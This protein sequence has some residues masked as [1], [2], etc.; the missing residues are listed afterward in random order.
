MKVNTPQTSMTLAT[1][2]MLESPV[3][4]VAVVLLAC[5][6]DLILDVFRQV[7]IVIHKRCGQAG[8]QGTSLI[9]VHWLSHVLERW[10]GLCPAELLKALAGRYQA[11]CPN[12][13]FDQ[14]VSLF[15]SL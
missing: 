11:S 15:N 5:L 10:R 12:E 6:A 13:L 7:L 3:C 2:E 4:E 8:S 9:V 1:R 14:L